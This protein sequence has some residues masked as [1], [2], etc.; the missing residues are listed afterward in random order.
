MRCVLALITYVDVR[1]TYMYIAIFFYFKC[2]QE[3][4]LTETAGFERDKNPCYTSCRQYSALQIKSWCHI[5]TCMY[6]CVFVNVCNFCGGKFTIIEAAY[7]YV[8]HCNVVL[9][10]I[11][12]NAIFF[13]PFLEFSKSWW[14]MWLF[15]D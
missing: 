8:C 10:S 14:H 5:C 6:A 13:Y 11:S 15:L 7:L 4:G 12:I 2:L 1:C 9:Q 3:K